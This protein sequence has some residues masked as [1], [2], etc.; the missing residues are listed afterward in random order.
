MLFQGISPFET[1]PFAN[2]VLAWFRFVHFRLNFLS[3]SLQSECVTHSLSL[4]LWSSS[5]SE[6]SLA[7]K[8]SYLLCFGHFYSHTPTQIT[9]F[10]SNVWF[11]REK[12]S[13]GKI[14]IYLFGYLWR[15]CSDLC[16]LPSAGC[17]HVNTQTK[18]NCTFMLRPR[19]LFCESKRACVCMCAQLEVRI[20]INDSVVCFICYPR[21][22]ASVA[23]W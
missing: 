23:V 3:L 12:R 20:Q 17:V 16:R 15:I 10:I 4:R 2:M 22:R 9:E 19:P 21:V 5:K 8:P 14:P 13:R 1:R 18:K 11:E 7:A 6:N